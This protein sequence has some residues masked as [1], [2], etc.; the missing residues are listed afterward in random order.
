MNISKYF[1]IYLGLGIMLI[2][3]MLV[4]N[5]MVKLVFYLILVFLFLFLGYDFLKKRLTYYTPRV[6][7]IVW[8]LI[9]LYIVINKIREVFNKYNLFIIVF[10]IL[11]IIKMFFTKT[12]IVNKKG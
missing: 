9:I 10:G 11:F 6:S 2:S 4:P 3:S 7:E 12:K 5:S 8:D 1:Y